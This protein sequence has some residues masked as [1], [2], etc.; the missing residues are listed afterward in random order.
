M[1]RTWG[2]DDLTAALCTGEADIFT[3]FDACTFTCD[4][5]EVIEGAAAVGIAALLAGKVKVRALQSI[6]GL[7]HVQAPIEPVGL[8]VKT[9]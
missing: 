6:S 7:R 9:Q 4:N 8:Q 5:G 2:L 3:C 1:K